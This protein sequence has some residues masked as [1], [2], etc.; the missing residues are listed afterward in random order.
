MPTATAEPF[1]VVRDRAVYLPDADALVAADLHLGT[2]ATSAVEAPLEEGPA[3]VDR[4]GGLLDQFDPATVL[5]AGDVLHAFDSVPRAART[6]L[7]SLADRVMAAGAE[8]VVIEGNHD[9][10][11]ATLDEVEPVAVHELADGTVVCHGHERPAVTGRRYVVGHDHPVIG[12]EGRRRPCALYGPE[13]HGGADVLALPAFNPAVRGTAV[14]TWEDDDPLSPF[15][16]N[17]SQFHP[18]VWPGSGEEP[19]V[20]P[21]LGSLLPY[22]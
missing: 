5:L 21:K 10:Q 16:A 18:V 7:D 17:V 3:I 1:G 13:I 20:F 14:D 4:L 11:L 2:V 8:L 12:I 19:L 15:L 22:L 9:T 6:A